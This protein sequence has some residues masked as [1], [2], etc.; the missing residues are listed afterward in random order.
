MWFLFPSSC[1]CGTGWL[2]RVVPS[3]VWRVVFGSGGQ[4]T[5]ASRDGRKR[6]RQCGGE[7]CRLRKGLVEA[8]GVQHFAGIRPGIGWKFLDICICTFIHWFL[9]LVVGV[10]DRGDVRGR[11]VWGTPLVWCG[12]GVFAG[13]R[14]ERVSPSTPSTVQVR[15]GLP[16]SAH[17]RGTPFSATQQKG[18]S[19][20]NDRR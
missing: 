15:R 9:G 8:L 13:G 3:R 12:R 1:G 20:K 16:P 19:R 4:G 5:R 14:G 17:K 18:S 6:E 10:S 11:G 7:S 2:W